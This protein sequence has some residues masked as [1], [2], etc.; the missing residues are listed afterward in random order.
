MFKIFSKY[1][2]QNHQSIICDLFYAI[3]YNITQCCCCNNKSYTYKYYSLL[4]FPME[5]VK[6]FKFSENNKIQ[7]IK[8]YKNYSNNFKNKSL[9]NNTN[10][11]CINNENQN[12]IDIIE[13]FEYYKKVN[14][15]SGNKSI[16]CNNCDKIC[17]YSTCTLLA[18]G[19]KLLY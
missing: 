17:S 14:I 5:E 11:N 10:N 7:K 8:N 6:Y 1:F 12:E 4:K 19:P 9:S 2:I 16:Y 3:N 18:T 13:F 15:L